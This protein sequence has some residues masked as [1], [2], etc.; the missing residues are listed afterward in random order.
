MAAVAAAAPAAAAA[1]DAA[2]RDPIPV[3]L[4]PVSVPDVVEDRR[5]DAAGAIVVRKYVKGK[6]LGK[7]RAR[8]R[9]R[10]VARLFRPRVRGCCCLHSPAAAGLLR[11]PAAHERVRAFVVLWAVVRVARAQALRRH[12]A[13]AA[14]PAPRALCPPPRAGRLC[15]L[16]RL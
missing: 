11:R 10:L 7:V 13:A 1:P 16:L 9:T 8:A 12:L 5:T 6:L 2:G 4:A 14:A 3:A 15:A